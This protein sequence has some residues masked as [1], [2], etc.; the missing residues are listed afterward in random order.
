MDLTD[1]EDAI[2]SSVISN[3]VP[4]DQNISLDRRLPLETGM[5]F[6]LSSPSQSSI[7]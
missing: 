4:F 6:S 1:L 3:S 7:K 5:Y 2:F